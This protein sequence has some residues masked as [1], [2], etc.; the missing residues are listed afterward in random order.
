M[1]KEVL[2]ATSP[3]ADGA[4]AEA[5]VEIPTKRRHAPQSTQPRSA[6]SEEDRRARA[7]QRGP[8]DLGSSA[9]RRKLF[10]R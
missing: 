5:D 2:R 3:P 1:A 7:L 4:L 8:D 10:G 6:R 9:Q